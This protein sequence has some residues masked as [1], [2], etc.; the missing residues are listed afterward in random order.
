MNPEVASPYPTPM[1]QDPNDRR[2]DEDRIKGG[3]LELLVYI[4]AVIAALFIVASSSSCSTHRNVSEIKTIKG[5]SLTTSVAQS[6]SISQKDTC[7]SQAVHVFNS[8]AVEEK[9]S[10]NTETEIVTEQIIET[11]DSLGN[12]TTTTNRTTTRQRKATTQS[13]S[14]LNQYKEEID[15]QLR[16]SEM[17]AQYDSLMQL[18]YKHWNDSIARQEETTRQPAKPSFLSSFVNWFFQCAFAVV[19]LVLLYLSVEYWMNK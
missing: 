4:I 16:L 2:T 12:R 8:S 10:E 17:T 5:D 3:C 9:A 19:L 1:P 11:T 6:V 18:S 14:L 7:A 13:Q 15:L